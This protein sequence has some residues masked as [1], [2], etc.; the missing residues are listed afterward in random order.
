MAPHPRTGPPAEAL[1][2]PPRRA[3]VLL[4]L[5]EKDGTPHLVLTRRND[6]LPS[7]A[8]QIA[9]PGGGAE[10][11]DVSLWKTAI[12][13]ARE[14]LG[15]GEAAQEI[16]YLGRL[17]ATYIASSHFQVYP[18]VGWLERAPTF[19]PFAEEVAEVF[20][21]P[22]A[23]LLDDSRKGQEMRFLHGREVIVPHYFWEG[24]IIW[25]ATAMILSEFEMLLR[26]ELADLEKGK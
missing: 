12:R 4:L 14:E 8:G 6:T 11:E 17:S 22:V 16:I 25:G 20:V 2:L 18:F 5:F 7:H 3:G 15:L 10:L 23:F 26:V 13:E 1:A 9:L 21:V 19:A 24:R